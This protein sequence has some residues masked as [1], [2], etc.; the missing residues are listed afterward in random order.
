M[1]R[2]GHR[3]VVGVEGEM[4]VGGGSEKVG[5]GRGGDF[6]FLDGNKGEGEVG[7]D[8]FGLLVRRPAD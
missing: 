7:I 3:G 6:C 2:E 8:N 5:V 1:R 4:E